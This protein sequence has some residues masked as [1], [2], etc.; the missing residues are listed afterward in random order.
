M[1]HKKGVG[2]SKNGRD[3]NPKFLGVNVTM[4]RSSLP[5]AFSS[6]SVAHASIPVPMSNAG[7]TTHSLP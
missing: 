5:A 7:K 3:S 2:S 4:A 6:A 1:A